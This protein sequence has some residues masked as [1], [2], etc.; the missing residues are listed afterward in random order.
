[1][2]VMLEIF[3]HSNPADS[4]QESEACLSVQVLHTSAGLRAQAFQGLMTEPAI[5][6]IQVCTCFPNSNPLKGTFEALWVKPGLPHSVCQCSTLDTL[7]LSLQLSAPFCLVV[8]SLYS[9]VKL[10]RVECSRIL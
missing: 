6:T 7:P 5:G 1:M 10:I 2:N 3:E 9:F 4:C 8:M